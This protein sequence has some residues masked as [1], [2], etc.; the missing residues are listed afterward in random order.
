MTARDETEA[1]A[2]G[3]R[4]HIRATISRARAA[5]ADARALAARSSANLARSLALAGDSQTKVQASLALRAQLRASVTAY[6]TGLK[7]DGMPSERVLVLVKAAIREAT[8][9][10]FDPYDARDLMEEAVRWTVEA[11][12]HAA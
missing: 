11:Y 2:L 6:V 12:Y 7:A 1:P 5:L 9:P 10:D 4:A 8:P 3:S